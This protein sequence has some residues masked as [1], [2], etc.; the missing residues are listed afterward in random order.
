M[1]LRIGSGLSF[2][3]YAAYSPYSLGLGGTG[4]VS[5]TKATGAVTGSEGD[6]KDAQGVHKTSPAECK[7]CKARKYKDGSD[8]MVSFKT[9]QHISP[10][11]AGAAVRAHEGEH[12]SNAYKE[13]AQN[14]GQVLRASVSIHMAVCPECGRS[15]VSGGLTRTAIKYT[16]EDNP[17]NKDRKAQHE[18]A[19]AG[20]NI[21]LAV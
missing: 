10:T 21:D 16:N 11:Q 6:V 4:S 19:L 20:Q 8:E 18:D 2:G 13:A 3:G 15:Y 12:V 7:T 9:A 14:D 17:Y 5:D 1:S